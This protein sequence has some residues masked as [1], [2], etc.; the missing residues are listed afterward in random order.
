[1]EALVKKMVIVLAL[2]CAIV[3]NI[4]AKSKSTHRTRTAKPVATA[5]QSGDADT[6]LC[7]AASHTLVGA[8]GRDLKNE[9]SSA[10]K[11][12]GLSNAVAVCGGRAPK[13]AASHSGSGWTIRRIGARDTTVARDS[14]LKAMIVEFKD[15]RKTR[16]TFKDVWT[17]NADSTRIYHFYE[18][19]FAQDFCLKCH[20][21]KETVDQPVLD[22]IASGYSVDRTTGFSSGELLGLFVV[23]AQWP[24][25]QSQ[26]RM[27]TAH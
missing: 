24:A 18:P 15:A 7:R 6:R 27:L 17:T 20:G 16:P 14:L 5:D 26:A 11:H 1:V 25:G 2:V 12:G 19:M 23:E 21:S 4:S 22:S 8:F 3:P 9:I 13:I 10:M